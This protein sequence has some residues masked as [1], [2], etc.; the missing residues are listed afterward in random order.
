M[1]KE[2]KFIII[3]FIVTWFKSGLFRYFPGTIGS[4]AS[5]PFAALIMFFGGPLYLI[6]FTLIF[7]IF[8][9][10]FSDKYS[11]LLNKKDPQEVVIDEVVGQWMVLIFVP[12]DIYLYILALVI[13][14]FFDILKPWPI[15]IFDKKYGGGFGIMIDDIIAAIYSIIL[16]ISI[17]KIFLI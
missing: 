12:L 14:R 9:V 11:K 13:F 7:F 8:G 15:N 6:L 3:Q 5:L 17:E 10:Y 2:F 4:I 1:S 16:F